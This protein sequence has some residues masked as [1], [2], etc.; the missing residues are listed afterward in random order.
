MDTVKKTKQ[1]AIVEPN[2]S[3]RPP[4]PF[5]S[6]GTFRS[7]AVKMTESIVAKTK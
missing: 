1:E 5:L 4:R 2:I 7:I 6:E 3:S